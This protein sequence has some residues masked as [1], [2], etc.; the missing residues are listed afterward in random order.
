MFGCSY[1]LGNAATLLWLPSFADKYG[2]KKIF[3][4][5]MVAQFLLYIGLLVTSH[6]GVM[7]SV[8][9]CFGFLASVRVAVGYVYLLELMPKKAQT[10]VTSIWNV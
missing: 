10:P 7:I 6:I 3:W 2:R 9:V 4:I 1:W 5:T 8:W